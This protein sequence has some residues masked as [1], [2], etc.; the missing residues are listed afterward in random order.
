MFIHEGS[1]KAFKRY[2]DMLQS[3]SIKSFED[4]ENPTSLEH[5]HFMCDTCIKALTDKKFEMSVDKFSRWM[6][7]IQAILIVNKY[8]TV[9]IERNTTREW[10]K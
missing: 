10:L 2:K 9:E 3:K 5:V 4:L 8:T 1:L 6:G 7:Y